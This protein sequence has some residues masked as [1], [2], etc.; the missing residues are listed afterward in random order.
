VGQTTRACGFGQGHVDVLEQGQSI[1][2]CLAGS[3][4]G[5]PNQI[6]G[7]FQQDGDDAFL[8]GGGLF[9]SCCGNGFEEPVVQSHFT[10]LHWRSFKKGAVRLL[11]RTAH[12]CFERS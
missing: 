12:G 1:C 5:E 4:L 6:D 9:K 11:N 7:F 10:E 8:D 3:G 2:R